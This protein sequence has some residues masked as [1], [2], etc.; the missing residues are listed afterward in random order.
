MISLT[1]NGAEVEALLGAKLTLSKFRP[2]VRLAGGIREIINL[3]V[4]F[5]K[6][7]RKFKLL[8]LCWG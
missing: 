2:R 4:I 5:V 8:C 3:F 1:L 6:L 7:F